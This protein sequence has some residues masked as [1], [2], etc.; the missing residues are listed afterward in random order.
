MPGGRRVRV[1][2]QQRPQYVQ[3]IGTGEGDAVGALLGGAVFA[4]HDRRAYAGPH[5]GDN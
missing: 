3:R 5:E 1:D 4:R 2:F